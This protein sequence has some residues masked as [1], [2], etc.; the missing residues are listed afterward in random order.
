MREKQPALTN[1]KSVVFHRDNARPHT[2]LVV[3]KK[4]RS[5]GCEVMQHPYSLDLV[6]SDYHLFRSLQNNIDKPSEIIL[7]IFSLTSPRSFTSSWPYRRIDPGIGPPTSVSITACIAGSVS[8]F[9]RSRCGP[10]WSGSSLDAPEGHVLPPIWIALLGLGLC[11]V[12]QF[13]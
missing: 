12:L 13:C 2:S 3:K 5:F 7:P 11:S 8:L 4:L 6:P 9:D 1:R 10:S